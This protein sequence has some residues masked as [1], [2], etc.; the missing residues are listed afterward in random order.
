M[1][2]LLSVARKAQIARATK[3]DGTLP[4]LETLFTSPDFTEALGI[5]VYSPR[6]IKSS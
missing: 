2:L 1:F 5:Q 4:P 6:T 3:S